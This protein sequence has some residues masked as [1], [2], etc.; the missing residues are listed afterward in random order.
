MRGIIA[1]YER[2][3]I[4]ERTARGQR[5]RAQA[6][7]I[8]GGTVPLGYVAQ[9]DRYVIDPEE[10]ALVRR[11]FALSLDGMSQEAIASLLTREGITP[12]GD[13]KPGPGRRLKVSVWHQ[14]SVQG[15]LHNTAYVGTLYYGKWQRIPGKRNP[16]RKTNWRA[17]EPDAWIAVPVPP[18]LDEA[19]FQAAQ[20]LAQRN[21]TQSRRN[22]KYEYLFIGGRLRCAQC[23][24]AM[25]GHANPRGSA[26]YRCT[27]RPVLD[28]VAP[29]TTRSIVA[30]DIEPVV[31][32]AVERAL[33]NLALIAAELDRRREGTST[34]KAD[35]DYERQQYERQ[36]AQ[37]EKDLKRWEAAYLGEA[38][39]LDDFKAK[40]A[41][42]DAR[43]SSAERELA[44]LDEQQR[45]LE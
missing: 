38:I 33:N 16:D 19:T 8:P 32:D 36:L 3:K 17:V 20:A 22:R 11:I 34:Q 9:G 27:R 44:Q 40:K 42:V 26:R 29:H 39:D 5:G 1:E 4:L 14:S 13:L 24:S 35:L 12:P 6:G 30:R 28:V 7:H 45:L 21:T 10:A 31:W 18:I 25:S 37:C 23:G 2:A 43:R 15:I 41:E